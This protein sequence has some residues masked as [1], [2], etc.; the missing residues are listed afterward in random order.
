MLKLVLV[1]G[2]KFEDSN[3]LYLITLDHLLIIAPISFS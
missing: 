3:N 1:R 2:S